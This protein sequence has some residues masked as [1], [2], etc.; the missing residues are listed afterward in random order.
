MIS[1]GKKKN[2]KPPF[3]FADQRAVKKR[4]YLSDEMY[5]MYDTCG[6]V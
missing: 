1:P 2:W 3:T 4:L 6:D 5:D